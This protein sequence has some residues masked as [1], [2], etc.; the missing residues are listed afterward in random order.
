[1]AGCLGPI[2]RAQAQSAA[3]KAVPLDQKNAQQ[4]R[5]LIDQGIQALG[6]QAYLTVHEMQEQGR[7]Y[8]FYHGRPTG[9]GVFF[10]R[11]LEYPDKER[12][13]L[14]P[15]RDIAYIYS[16]DKGFEVTYKGPRAVEKK[17]MDDYVRRHKFSLDTILRTWINDPGVALFY[18]GDALAG[19]LAA[20]RTSR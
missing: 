5:E 19:S 9:N 3:P 15:Q 4:A 14:T 6:G 10:W 18:D 20:R 1:M 7:T 17:D 11:F 16:A 12:I 13:E 2:A 8:T